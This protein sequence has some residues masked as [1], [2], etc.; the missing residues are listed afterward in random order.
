MWI[1]MHDNRFMVTRHYDGTNCVWMCL[2]LQSLNAL[3]LLEITKKE[4]LES[5]VSTNGFMSLYNTS[6]LQ[7]GSTV[8]FLVR[9]NVSSPF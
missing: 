6:L 5:K 1:L 8:R 4:I 2:Q 7:R 3:G 9:E